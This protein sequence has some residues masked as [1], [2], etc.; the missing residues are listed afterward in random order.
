MTGTEAQSRSQAESLD[1]SCKDGCCGKDESNTKAEAKSRDSSPDASCKDGC[2]DGDSKIIKIANRPEDSSSDASCQDACCD[3]DSNMGDKLG[4]PNIDLPP[5]TKP[6]VQ[7]GCCGDKQSCKCDESCIE[8]LA[9]RACIQ[10]CAGEQE[11]YQSS[12]PDHGSRSKSRSSCANHLESTRERFAATMDGLRC[13]CRALATLNL[14]SCCASNSRASS[15]KSR[16]SSPS[17]SSIRDRLGASATSTSRVYGTAPSKE[18]RKRCCAKKPEAIT[19]QEKPLGSIDSE[20]CQEECCDAPKNDNSSKKEIKVSTTVDLEKGPSFLEHVAL[21]VTGMTCTGCEKKLDRVLNGLNQATNVKTSLVTSRAEF[22]VDVSLATV[23]E[24][25]QYVQTATGFSCDLIT[26]KGAELDLQM[27]DMPETLSIKGV[28]G[29]EVGKDGVRV[30]YDPTVIGARELIDALGNPELAPLKPDPS[31]S[32]GAQHVRYLSYVTAASIALTIPIL[33]L[34]YAP[35]PKHDVAY[36]A[37]SLALA[38]LIQFAIA[39]PFYVAAFKSLIFSKMV[40]LDFLIV[41]S[42]S[43]AYIFSLISFAFLVKGQPLS[44]GEF[45]ETSALL[46]TLIT[47]GKLLSAF[48]RQQA[49][50]SVSVRSLQPQTANIIEPEKATIDSRLLQYCDIFE[51]A[52][53]SSIVTDGTVTAG[54][55][56]VNESMITGESVPVPKSSGSRVIAGS[57]NGSGKLTVRLTRLPNENTVTAIASMVDQAK[58]SKP[59]MQAIADRVAGWFIPVVVTISLVTFAVWMGVG[60]RVQSK[61][62]GEAAIQGLTYAIATLIVSCPCAIGLAVPMVVVIVSGLAAKRGIVFKDSQAIEVAHKT[63]H[64]VFDKTGTLTEGKLTVTQSEYFHP[65]AA[66]ILLGLID[67]VKHPVSVA[68]AQ[69]LK[70]QKTQTA[71]LSDIRTLPGKGIEATFTPHNGPK[72]TIRGGNPHWLS[73]TTDPTLLPLPRASTTFCLTIGSTKAAIFSLADTLRPSSL[74]TITSLRALGI[75]SISIVSG[76][77]VGPV[78]AIAAE[79]GIPESNAHA[80]CSPGDKKNF[81]ESLPSGEV[82]IFI[83]DGTNDAVALAQATVGIHMSDNPDSTSSSSSD[84]ASSTASIVLTGSS[85]DGVLGV[86]ALSRAA[87]QRIVFNFAWSGVYNLFAIL[88][89]AGAFVRAR[90]PPAYAGLGEIV[91]VLPVVLAAVALRWVRV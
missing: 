40:E 14:E 77:D 86:I 9:Q 80:R 64:V 39:G 76:D 68:L 42:T 24:T 66:S 58:L 82:S 87:Y 48:A 10:E 23:A 11:K 13:I 16:K 45:F 63:K 54:T 85:L 65:D 60:T 44:T 62:A 37:A 50:Q 17:R 33:V 20:T 51:V 30:F 75:T 47:V 15:C 70:S 84:I 90:I 72:T 67:G 36:G 91:S 43:A 41:L 89:A 18:C 29:S 74:P 7:T 59:K 32:A 56:D 6:K 31:I 1:T 35:L 53:E 22:D 27:K 34:A 38:T 49:I 8:R 26:F 88:L 21:S 52:P 28:T 57:I 5:A 12:F 73:L 4:K 78:Q 79:L 2:C 46:V 25:I 69:H 83:G 71:K 55:S 19:I 81:I 61:S 3:E